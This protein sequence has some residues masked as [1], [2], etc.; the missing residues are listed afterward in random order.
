MRKSIEDAASARAEAPRKLESVDARMAKLSEE[1]AAMNARMDAE[2]A[3]EA[4]AMRETVPQRSSGPEAGGVHG[5]Q[6]VKKA[7]ASCSRRPP[8]CAPGPPKSWS[9]SRCLPRTGAAGHG[10]YREDRGDRPVIAGSLARRYARALLDIGKEEGQLRRSLTEVEGFAKSSRARPSSGTRWNRRTSAGSPSR[11]RSRRCWPGRT[12]S[13]DEVVP[14]PA[15]RQGTDERPPGDP[16]RAAPHGRESEGIERV[17]VTVPIPLSVPQKD[18]L[19]AVL[20][21]RTGKK[22]LLEE[23]VDASVLGGM[24]V[25]VGST[26]YDGSVRTQIQQIRQNLQKG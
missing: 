6:E 4:K 18:G 13:H 21:R 5:E 8:R 11:P 15:D 16:V 26:V 10:E 25:R 24:V 2:T 12:T 14:R 20:E 22:V 23:S 17:E 1:I 3:A 7:R 19:R 9:A